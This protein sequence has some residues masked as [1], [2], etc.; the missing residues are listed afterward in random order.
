[1][2]VRLASSVPSD[3]LIKAV[4]GD[5]PTAALKPAD[6]ATTPSTEA[7]IALAQSIMGTKNDIWLREI[8]F[9][10]SL[11]CLVSRGD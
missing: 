10:Q 4:L 5:D 3:N 9:V 7:A 2:P 8:A 11:S 6:G 1:M